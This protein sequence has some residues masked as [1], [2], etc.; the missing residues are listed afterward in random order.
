MMDVPGNAYSFHLHDANKNVMEITNDIG[1][2]DVYASYSP[3]G[4]ITNN[5]LTIAHESLFFDS[6]LTLLLLHDQ[7]FSP[8]IGLFFRQ[9]NVSD[10]MVT[11]DIIL[12]IYGFVTNLS[13]NKTVRNASELG[14]A[15]CNNIT[16][17]MEIE[18]GLIEHPGTNCVQQHEQQHVENGKACCKNYAR[19]LQKARRRNDYSGAGKCYKK[20]KDWHDNKQQKQWDECSAH[21]AEKNCL[22]KKIGDCPRDPE[23]NYENLEEEVEKLKLYLKNKGCSSE[24]SAQECPL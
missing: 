4:N 14:K 22:E 23:V 20:Y 2:T 16:G 5:Q 19:C 7:Y 9:H 18:P 3:F 17:E 10:G 24:L 8:K 15:K 21:A 13:A 1:V 6:E 11:P 12:L